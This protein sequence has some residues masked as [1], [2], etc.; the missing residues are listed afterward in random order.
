MEQKFGVI[1][2]YIKL[3]ISFDIKN[4]E[5]QENESLLMGEDHPRFI[6][7]A[8]ATIRKEDKAKAQ[9]K[10]KMIKLKQELQKDKEVWPYFYLLINGA[11]NLT[12]EMKEMIEGLKNNGKIDDSLLEE[13]AV[14]MTLF[15]EGIDESTD[16]DEAIKKLYRKRFI[17]GFVVLLDIAAKN[18]SSKVANVIDLFMRANPDFEVYGLLAPTTQYIS[19]LV[20]E[21]DFSYQKLLDEN[22]QVDDEIS[23]RIALQ[24]FSYM[25]NE[26]ADFALQKIKF[27]ELV[28][29]AK[30]N[31]EGESSI[32]FIIN[33]NAVRFIFKLKI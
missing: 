6:N 21:K 19:L 22:K 7:A 29:V 5:N 18:R 17:S 3:K 8:K 12:E 1:Q 31:P 27:G 25:E 20:Q 26:G 11:S 32:D 33:F 9:I 4:Q 28:D 16:L 24:I 23:A 15:I 10:N 2:K 30:K 14:Q 13:I